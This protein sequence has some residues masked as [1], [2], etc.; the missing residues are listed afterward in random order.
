LRI[1]FD[2]LNRFKIGRAGITRFYQ[3]LANLNMIYFDLVGL[4]D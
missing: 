3:V 4:R 2:D 1:Y